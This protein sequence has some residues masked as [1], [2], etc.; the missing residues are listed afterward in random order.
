[1]STSDWIA[2]AGIAM[3]FFIA[4]LGS[5]WHLSSSI[6]NLNAR[7]TIIEKTLQTL[8]ETVAV[9]KNDITEIRIEL[10]EM[11]GKLE[12][13]WKVHVSQSNSPI[14]LND[15]GRDILAKTNIGAFAEQHYPEILSKVRSF[16]PGN[17]YQ[18]Q[19]V[20]ISIVGR[21]KRE[22]EYRLMLQ[23]I[24][25]SSGYDIDSLLFVAALSIRDRVISDLG[26]ARN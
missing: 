25:F 8:V 1:M 22:H 21:Y 26:L 24:A 3:A 12:I 4:L 6:A 17:A 23:E 20:L 13:L 15:V 9:M 11:R 14:S 5:V 2:I 16:T 18:A 10:A 7:V 19:E